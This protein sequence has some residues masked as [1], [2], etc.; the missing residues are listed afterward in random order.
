[1]MDGREVLHSVSLGLLA[2]LPVTFSTSWAAR[3][4]HVALAFPQN[5]ATEPVGR[6]PQELCE[7]RGGRP[8]FPSLISLR[9]LW[10]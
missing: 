6:R 3:S 2:L 9:L 5:A 4:L 10:T 8:G 1:M 7:S